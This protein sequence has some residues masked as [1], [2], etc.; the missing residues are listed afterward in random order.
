MVTGPEAGHTR[1][2][3]L[4]TIVILW[5]FLR[6]PHLFFCTALYC[7]CGSRRNQTIH[8]L[9]ISHFYLRAVLYDMLQ[10]N[11][12]SHLFFSD[13]L[14]RFPRWETSQARVTHACVSPL[15]ALT[16]WWR[17]RCPSLLLRDAYA[18]LFGHG[19]TAGVCCA[20]FVSH[21]CMLLRARVSAP[22]G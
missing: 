12:P 5:R 15:H 22:C 17:E 2:H 1:G 19:T 21:C 20:L 4:G 14:V 8:V 9:F 10:Y 6:S 18:C 16:F 11:I 7:W 3:S 13:G